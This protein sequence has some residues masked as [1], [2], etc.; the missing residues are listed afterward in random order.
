MNSIW[1][2]SIPSF[3]SK[4]HLHRQFNTLKNNMLISED[5]LDGDI[6]FNILLNAHMNGSYLVGV[7]I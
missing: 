4:Q 5:V 1:E 2:N 3:I 7:V 6:L